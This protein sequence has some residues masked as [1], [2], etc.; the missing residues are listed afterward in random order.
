MP[1]SASFRHVS[2][3]KY[4]RN[5]AQGESRR[6]VRVLR[7]DRPQTVLLPHPDYKPYN[8]SNGKIVYSPPDHMVY[9]RNE[10]EAVLA[11]KKSGNWY[12]RGVG[13][14]P[15]FGREGLTWQLISSRLKTRYLPEDYILD[16]GTPCGFLRPGMPHEELF[17]ILAWT[18]SPL[19]SHILKSVI[20]HTIN[21]QSKDFERCPTRTGFDRKSK[22]KWF[23]QWET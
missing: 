8:K 18:L 1:G 6:C 10:G 16:S 14:Q 2:R 11:F 7:R 20:N 17:F 21:I 5:N 12:L 4:V 19:C 13:G 23:A 3:S 9:W 22:A 15:F